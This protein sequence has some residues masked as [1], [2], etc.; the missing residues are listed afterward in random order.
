MASTGLARGKADPAHL[1]LL[2]LHKHVFQWTDVCAGNVFLVKA[3]VE[4]V[5]IEEPTSSLV[6]AYI[7]YLRLPTSLDDATVSV[8]H[9]ESLETSDPRTCNDALE[10]QGS[11]CPEEGMG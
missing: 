1:I 5:G 9:L 4:S 2:G 6:A 10:F 7:R 3:L 8:K 11:E